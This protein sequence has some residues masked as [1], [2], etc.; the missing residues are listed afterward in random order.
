MGSL[1]SPTLRPLYPRERTGAHCMGGWM[2]SR[3]GLAG[4]G[5]S[6]PHRDSIPWSSNY[7][8]YATPAQNIYYRDVNRRSTILHAGTLPQPQLQYREQQESMN[9]LSI[10]TSWTFF[11]RVRRK[12]FFSRAVILAC[13]RNTVVE[14]WIHKWYKVCIAWF[15]C[16]YLE[17]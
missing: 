8:D 5:K 6:R 14:C 11:A 9:F 12:C 15:L 1:V 10:I 4:Y 7:T 2:G 17:S 3:T 16:N 13:I